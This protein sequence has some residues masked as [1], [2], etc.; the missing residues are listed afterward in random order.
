MLKGLLKL[1]TFIT[2][3]R[4]LY[5]RITLITNNRKILKVFYP[6]FPPDRNTDEVLH[7]LRKDA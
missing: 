1:P 3:G 6:V 4:E 7:W 5:N 2:A